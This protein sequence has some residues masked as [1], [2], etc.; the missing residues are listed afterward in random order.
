M[1]LHL[2]LHVLSLVCIVLGLVAI[3]L[4]KRLPQEATPT[5]SS[6]DMGYSSRT[7]SVH[8]WVGIAT[9]GLWGLQ[10]LGG[11][12]KRLLRPSPANAE[13]VHRAHAFL[14]KAAFAGGVA[15]CAL[16][17]EDM[18]AGDL[19]G[20]SYA[21]L[22]RDSLLASGASIVLLFLAVVT[23]A[24]MEHASFARTQATA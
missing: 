3:V 5:T 18:Q 9:L 19:A 23:L 12:A 24:A 13:A 16:G 10:L 6:T 8:S 1:R 17:F 20:A 22:S 14:G 2:L 4:Y 11:M 7:Y 21:P 15:S